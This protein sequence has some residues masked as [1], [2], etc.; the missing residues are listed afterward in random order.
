MRKFSDIC[1]TIF[2]AGILLCLFAGGVSAL[3]YIAALIIGGE[4][5]TAL[6]VWIHKTYFP[7]VIRT[8]ALMAAIGLLGMY[9]GKIKAFVLNEKKK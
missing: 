8:T 9:F 4:T 3:G 6:C 1:L 5:A 7:V 2:A